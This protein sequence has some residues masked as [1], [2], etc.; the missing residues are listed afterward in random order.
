MKYNHGLNKKS[1]SATSNRP[2]ISKN[3]TKAKENSLHNIYPH[4]ATK[5]AKGLF[6]W[7]NLQQNLNI[8]RR[9]IMTSNQLQTLAVKN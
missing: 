4:W 1:T 3:N 8:P 7:K 2:A 6:N 9:K 5:T